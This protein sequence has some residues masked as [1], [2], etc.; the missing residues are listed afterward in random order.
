MGSCFFLHFLLAAGGCS[1]EWCSAA[2]ASFALHLALA[3][4]AMILGS[5]IPSCDHQH[6]GTCSTT[7]ALIHSSQHLTPSVSGIGDR[8][9]GIERTYARA[10]LLDHGSIQ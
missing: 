10:H 4:M 7:Q 5:L 6:S 9:K 3:S 2:V 1:S 8:G